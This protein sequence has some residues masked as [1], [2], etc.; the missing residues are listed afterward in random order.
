LR[1][2]GAIAGWGLHPLENAAFARRTPKTD[3]TDFA[4]N[5]EFRGGFPSIHRAQYPSFHFG[6]DAILI[7]VPDLHS[8]SR[9]HRYLD[10]NFSVHALCTNC[11]AL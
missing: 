9:F 1:P 6:K 3:I 10:G 11:S 8:L 5:S 2:A 4:T 7:Y